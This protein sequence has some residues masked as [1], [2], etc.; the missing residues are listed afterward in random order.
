MSTLCAKTEQSQPPEQCRKI[1]KDEILKAIEQLNDI[2]G[3]LSEQEIIVFINDFCKEVWLKTK[4]SLFLFK[5]INRFHFFL[6]ILLNLQFPRH[7]EPTNPLKTDL[8]NESQQNGHASNSSNQK[9][10]VDTKNQNETISKVIEVF[11][12]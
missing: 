8:S 11:F 2:N 10:D 12:I 1:S 9:F 6:Q 3:Q 4:T 7:S 5:F